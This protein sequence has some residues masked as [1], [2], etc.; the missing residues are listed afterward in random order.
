MLKHLDQTKTVKM[1]EAFG[2]KR[3]ITYCSY[4]TADLDKREWWPTSWPQE[5]GGIL[6]TVVGGV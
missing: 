2:M 3:P 6:Q 1:E 5:E 4:G